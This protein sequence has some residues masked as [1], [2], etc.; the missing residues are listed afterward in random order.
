MNAFFWAIAI[1]AQL[2]FGQFLPFYSPDVLPVPL[3]QLDASPI[4]TCFNME[5]CLHTIH[6][7]TET[8]EYTSMYLFQ[9]HSQSLDQLRLLQSIQ[10]SMHPTVTLKSIPKGVECKD[11]IPY[12]ESITRLSESMNDFCFYSCFVN[13][14]LRSSDPMVGNPSFLK[15]DESDISQGP[16]VVSSK[17]QSLYLLFFILVVTMIAVIVANHDKGHPYRGAKSPTAAFSLKAY[18]VTI[19]TLLYGLWSSV[20]HATTYATRI[21]GVIVKTQ[22][23]IFVDLMTVNLLFQC[24]PYVLGTLHHVASTGFHITTVSVTSFTIM[25]NTIVRILLSIIFDFLFVVLVTLDR[26]AFIVFSVTLASG[27]FLKVATPWILSEASKAVAAWFLSYVIDVY[28]L[29]CYLTLI[30]YQPITRAKDL[31]NSSYDLT[32]RT[33]ESFYKHLAVILKKHGDAVSSCIRE[34]KQVWINACQRFALNLLGLIPILCHL[35]HQ[36]CIHI[37]IGVKYLIWCAADCVQEFS[38]ILHLILK[39]SRKSV[40]EGL[41]NLIQIAV[42]AFIFYMIYRCGT[43]TARIVESFLYLSPHSI[44]LPV[45]VEMRLL[46]FWEQI[47][48]WFFFTLIHI[49]PAGF[50]LEFRDVCRKFG[51]QPLKPMLVYMLLIRIAERCIIDYSST[52]HYAQASTLTV[53]PLLYCVADFYGIPMTFPHIPRKSGKHYC[54]TMRRS[55]KSDKPEGLLVSGRTQVQSQR[56]SILETFSVDTEVESHRFSSTRKNHSSNYSKLRNVVSSRSSQTLTTT[57][58]F[59]D[60]SNPFFSDRRKILTPNSTPLSEPLTSPASYANSTGSSFIH[61]FESHSV[62]MLEEPTQYTIDSH[63]DTLSVSILDEPTSDIPNINELSH[64]TTIR[65]SR[66]APDAY[67]YNGRYT[68]FQSPQFIDSVKTAHFFEAANPFYTGNRRVSPTNTPSAIQP[69]TSPGSM[70]GDLND[71]VN[72][73]LD[74]SAGSAEHAS[75][76]LTET[77]LDVNASSVGNET[78]L[79]EETVNYTEDSLPVDFSQADEYQVNSTSSVEESIAHTEESFLENYSVDIVSDISESDTA[80]V[81]DSVT[82]TEENDAAETSQILINLDFYDPTNPFL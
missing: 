48:Y 3:L 76:S 8:R 82:D 63:V 12:D 47:C 6:T 64:N 73:P 39:Y 71:S 46:I 60:T 13:R 10:I 74:Y 45:S 75:S 61:D 28:S 24:Y 14:T 43:T 25:L 5:Q 19:K 54:H 37:L 44:G 59:F 38:A 65:K 18:A 17:N 4:G 29:T 62:S 7:V 15:L 34:N 20:S 77:A 67:S 41:S 27:N 36:L 57:S 69:L 23:P 26:L 11:V 53:F 22:F 52:F 58:P 21:A 72:H 49:L 33:V 68:A 56:L 50:G 1:V 66:T 32:Q 16:N 35:S 51:K 79:I 30:P 9:D 55:A 31:L 42:T 80:F 2:Y 40:I 81:S 70:Y 78:D